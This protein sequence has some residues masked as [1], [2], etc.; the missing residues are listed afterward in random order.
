M[1]DGIDRISDLSAVGS[2]IIRNCRISCRRARPILIKSR[3][4]LIENCTIY[5]SHSPGIQAGSEM[6]WDEGPQTLNLTVR[7][8]TFENIDTAA[9]DVGLFADGS[10]T[11]LDCKNILI[12][13]NVFKNNGQRTTARPW[14]KWDTVPKESASASA[15]RTARSY[16]TTRSSTTLGR[17]SSCS[18]AKTS[19]SSATSSR[20][21][22]RNCER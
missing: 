3:D 15:T 11:S 14:M 2:A 19:S 9:V 4:A 12:E 21:L 22:T 1:R 20:K 8:C 5:D 6:Y 7:G 13:N 10:D 18:I 17:I 16:A